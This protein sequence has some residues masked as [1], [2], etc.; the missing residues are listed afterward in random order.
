MRPVLLPPA[1]VQHLVSTC[2]VPIRSCVLASLSAHPHP[3]PDCCCVSL[4]PPFPSSLSQTTAPRATMMMVVVALAR[5]RQC[6]EYAQPG[7]VEDQR[8][9]GAAARAKACPAHGLGLAPALGSA[10]ETPTHRHT[11]RHTDTYTDTHTHTHTHTHRHRH[12]QTHRRAVRQQTREMKLKA[13]NRDPDSLD[14]RA[15]RRAAHVGCR[16]P[17]RHTAST[18]AGTPRARGGESGGVGWPVLRTC[19]GGW[20]HA[21]VQVQQVTT[22]T[23]TDTHTGTRR[24]TDRH[25]HTHA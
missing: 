6:G 2:A 22:Q 4:L 20:M 14:S 7:T 25:T 10:K 18:A 21:V 24:Q 19:G 5:G 8:V 23:H 15:Q 12:T 17:P 1:V 13:D 16:R 9:A 3:H 11:F